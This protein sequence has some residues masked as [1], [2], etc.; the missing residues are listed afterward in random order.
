MS[1]F[2]LHN[3]LVN[4]WWLLRE[5]PFSHWPL[6]AIQMDKANKLVQQRD[7]R[8]VNGGTDIELEIS[9][10]TQIELHRNEKKIQKPTED[11]V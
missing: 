4:H 2:P 10:K 7:R 8:E 3:Q 9:N 6:P 5:I 11:V 1:L